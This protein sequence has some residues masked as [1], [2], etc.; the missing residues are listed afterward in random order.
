MTSVDSTGR[1]RARIRTMGLDRA[2]V[3]AA[4]QL[5]AATWGLPHL[6][7]GRGIRR[8]GRRLY[9][10]RMGREVRLI[11]APRGAVLVF[12]FAGGHDDVQDYLRNA[13]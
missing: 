2:E 4:M 9:E 5:C 11:F 10:C 8:L 12:D 7:S 3:F 13:K 6:H 1:F